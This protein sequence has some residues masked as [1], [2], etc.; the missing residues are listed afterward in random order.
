MTQDRFPIGHLND[1]DHIRRCKA[2]IVDLL[3][4]DGPQP[5]WKLDDVL[6]SPASGWADEMVKEGILVEA[7]CANPGYA[8]RPDMDGYAPIAGYGISPANTRDLFR[9]HR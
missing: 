6:D 3:L 8:F 1:P 9:Y 5:S 7:V 4:R 2:M